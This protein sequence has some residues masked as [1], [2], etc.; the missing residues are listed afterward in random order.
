MTGLGR[1]LAGAS[2][3]RAAREQKQKAGTCTGSLLLCLAVSKSSS[4]SVCEAATQGCEFGEVKLMGDHL[5]AIVLSLLPSI[6]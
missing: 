2:L 5:V 1:S 6:P 4:D 3:V